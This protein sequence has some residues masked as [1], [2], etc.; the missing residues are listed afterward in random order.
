[1]PE[2]GKGDMRIDGN[3]Q[4]VEYSRFLPKL[5]IHL[6]SISPQ[7]G[8]ISIHRVEAVYNTPYTWV[9]AEVGTRFF[10]VALSLFALFKK[11]QCTS[12]CSVIFRPLARYWA[13]HAIVDL[14]S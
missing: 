3:I 1:M 7:T 12:Q 13:I 4:M 14:K 6:P 5:K 8:L 10:L 9:I 11:A 2:G